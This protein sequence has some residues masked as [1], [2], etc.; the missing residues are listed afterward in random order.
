MDHELKDAACIAESG[1]F[2]EAINNGTLNEIEPG[3]VYVGFES[4]TGNNNNQY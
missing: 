4:R 2:T 3:D 1:R